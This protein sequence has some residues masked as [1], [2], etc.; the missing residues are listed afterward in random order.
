MY[1]HKGKAYHPQ[2]QGK[3]EGGHAPFKEALQKWM[4]KHGSNLMIG[5]YVANHEINQWAQWNR[6]NLSPY[7]MMY[8]KKV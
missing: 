2:S 8:G 3:V 1:A 5:V 7:N 6:D 4:A